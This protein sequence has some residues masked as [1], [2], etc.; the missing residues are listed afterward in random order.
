MPSPTAATAD[1]RSYVVDN[2]LTL[3]A[4]PAGWD[5]AAME[6]LRDAAPTVA[7]AGTAPLY[8]S[9]DSAGRRALASR[10]SA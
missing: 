6:V 3:G 10:V 9:L 8:R 2:L 7:C 5:A 4:H 1:L